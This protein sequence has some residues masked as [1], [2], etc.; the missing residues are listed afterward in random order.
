MD[1]LD[2]DQDRE[3]HRSPWLVRLAGGAAAIAVAIAVFPQLLDNLGNPREA[4][5]A[6]SA[7]PTPAAGPSRHAQSVPTLPP[8]TQTAAHVVLAADRLSVLDVDGG[9]TLTLM[10]PERY[11]SARPGDVVRLGETTVVLAGPPRTSAYEFSTRAFAV[12]DSGSAVDLGSAT[13]LLPA[14]SD[15]V[16]LT[17]R[18]NGQRMLRQVGLDGTERLP[19][20]ALP[21]DL[22]V[23]DAGPSS[24]LLGAQFGERPMP[25]VDWD[26]AS[27]QVITEIAD[28]GL[29]HDSDASRVLL[30][31]CD[32]CALRSYDRTTGVDTALTAL[33]A[34]WQL[35]SRA[36]LSPD[37]RHWS[38]VVSTTTQPTRRSIV[39]GHLPGSQYEADHSLL[40]DLPAVGRVAGPRM[41]WSSSGWLFVS[42]GYS[43][44]ALSPGPHQAFALDVRDHD[45]MAAG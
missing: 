35:T 26:P 6:A 38:G 23:V 16:W 27:G 10:L 31:E 2:N 9:H 5:P 44:W 25:I 30:Q 12:N 4:A 17:H 14:S 11:H 29:V 21:R 32:E 42:T 8:E 36:S 41:S 22:R 18:R 19:A 39:I 43:L 33:P 40:L 28:A 34:G 45:G 7:E 24:V 3:T 13:Q 20:R 1:V 37:G 15:A